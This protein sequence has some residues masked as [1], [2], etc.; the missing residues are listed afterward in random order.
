MEVPFQ[1]ELFTRKLELV[2]KGRSSG[3]LILAPSRPV[4]VGAVAMVT[5][6]Y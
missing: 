3:L 6:N 2:R 5:R 4:I 1:S